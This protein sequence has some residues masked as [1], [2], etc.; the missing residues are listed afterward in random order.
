MYKIVRFY[1]RAGRRVIKTG[2][3]LSQAQEHCKNPETSS[4]T[5]KGYK[6]R[7]RTERIGPWFDGYTAA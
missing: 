3:T 7:V 2:L 6:G 5:C 4:S 1:F